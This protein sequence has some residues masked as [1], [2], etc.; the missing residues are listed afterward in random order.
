MS[1]TRLITLA[2]TAVAFALPAAPALAN[3]S[4][5]F[6]VD[7]Q[8]WTVFDGGALV[9][10]ASGGNP[11]GFLQITD[12]TFGDFRLRLPAV[13]L[14][15]WSNYLGGSL[16]FDAK[17]LSNDAPDYPPFGQI[18]LTGGGQTVQADAVT[19]LLQPPTDGAWHHY[20]LTFNNATFGA[21]LPGV[22]AGLTELTLKAEFHDSSDG[23]FEV[24]GIDNIQV[25][26]AVPEPATWFM[27]L[28]GVLTVGRL[29]RYRRD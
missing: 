26:S 8:S 29:Q 7:A 3:L 1:P 28:A 17:N 18:S 23:R 4:Y 12:T 24:V 25:A 5:G 22:L 21:A 10:Q 6:D 15:N 14:G 20:T 27:L 13:A 11:G 19:A 16:S 9:H 2:A